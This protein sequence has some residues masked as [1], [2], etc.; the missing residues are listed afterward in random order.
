MTNDES[1]KPRVVPS[2]QGTSEQAGDPPVSEDVGNPPPANNGAPKSVVAPARGGSRLD[3]AKREQLLR[4]E[5]IQPQV[6]RLAAAPADRFSAELDS[7]IQTLKRSNPTRDDRRAV[8]EAAFAHIPPQLSG[9]I[10]AKHFKF[11]SDWNPDEVVAALRALEHAITNRRGQLHQL[12]PMLHGSLICLVGAAARFKPLPTE[13]STRDDV[14]GALVSLHR[15]VWDPSREPLA[16]LGDPKHG[17]VVGEACDLFATQLHRREVQEMMGQRLFGFA[18]VFA[19]QEELVPIADLTRESGNQGTASPQESPTRPPDSRT[20][21]TDASRSSASSSRVT[22][23]SKDRTLQDKVAKLQMEV[24]KLDALL[25]TSEKARTRLR[26]ELAVAQAQSA[27]LQR[28]SEG[29]PRLRESLALKAEELQLERERIDCLTASV[30]AER[31]RAAA[32]DREASRLRDELGQSQSQNSLAKDLEYQRG[33]KAMKAAISAH[34]VDSL[35]EIETAASRFEDAEGEF[36]RAMA[37]SLAR[38]LEE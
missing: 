30:Q 8:L 12:G 38:Y 18:R 37:A 35:R 13:S 2:V 17:K 20:P 34:C 33:R 10:V 21:C 11:G 25:E 3:A 6:D 4:A 29:I 14:V 16:D 1:P 26:E 9:L 36:I 28:A 19:P 5:R 22:A 7:I 24:T 27:V 15:L 23:S 31:D 32:S